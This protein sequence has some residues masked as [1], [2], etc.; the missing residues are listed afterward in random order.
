[1][2]PLAGAFA[3]ELVLLSAGYDA[4]AD[5]PLAGCEV[6]DD[7]YA[8]MAGS[9]RRM[10]DQLGVPVAMILEGGYDLGALAR[11]VERTLS[12]LGDPAAPPAPYLAV[13]PAAAGAAARLAARWPVLA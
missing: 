8:A 5:D 3:P 2:A 13:H 12:V 11:S 4:H 9:V 7:G 1:V 10:A 6:S